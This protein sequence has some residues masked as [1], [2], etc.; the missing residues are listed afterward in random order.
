MTASIS[1]CRRGSY[2]E[3]GVSLFIVIVLLLTVGLMTLTAF[4]LSRGQYR[5]VGNI[6][7]LEQAFNQTEA[8]TATAETWLNTTGNSKLA[9]FTTY[10]TAQ[11][12]LYPVGKLANLQLDPKTM[13]WSDTNSLASGNGRYLIEKL[14][15]NLRLPGGSLQME[16]RSSGACRAV[17]LFRIVSRSN[18]VRGS[19]RMIETTYAT[20][21]C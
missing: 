15:S 18:A 20:S 12:Y 5:L 1:Q 16:Q 13:T 4:Y 8:V 7:Y 2:R 21:A 10:S 17:D 14:A 6:Q 9:S 19:L 3:R 11:P